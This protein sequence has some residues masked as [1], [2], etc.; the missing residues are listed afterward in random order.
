MKNVGRNDP[1]PCGSGKKYK[2]CHGASNVIEMNPTHYNV[3]LVRLHLELVEFAVSE[4]ENEMKNAMEKYVHP[5]LLDDIEYMEMFMD[6]LMAWVLLQEPIVGNQTLFELYYKS[7]QNKIKNSRVK[8]TFAEWVNAVPSI[9][10]VLSVTEECITVKDVR[11]KET[12]QISQP[13]ENENEEGNLLLGILIPYVQEYDFFCTALEFSHINQEVT[14]L[15]EQLSDE[16]MIR[17]YPDILSS[18]I[19]I[20]AEPFEPEWDNPLYEM[21]A[22]LF[23]KHVKEKGAEENIISLG[24]YI[25]VIFTVKE[26]PVFKKPEA[27]AAALDYVLQHEVLMDPFQSQKDL[28]EEYK[29]SATTISKHFRK[30]TE[31]IGQELEM[32]ISEAMTVFD[33][34]DEEFAQA[35]SE[36]D[37]L[38]DHLIELKG[39]R[40]FESE[41]EV[42]QF[43]EEVLQ[44]QGL[45]EGAPR[46]PRDIAQEKLYEAQQ[47]KGAKRRSLIKEALEI[48]PNSPDAYLLMGLDAKTDNEKYQ[49]LHQAV[50]AGEKDLGKAFFEENKGHFW[51]IPE[52]RAYMRA[53]A[54][55]ANF[56]YYFGNNTAAIKDFEELLELNPND[57]QGIRDLLLPIY[58]VEGKFDDAK[59][60]INRYEQDVTA[61]FMF[62]H[63]LLYFYSEGLTAKTKSLLKKADQQNPYVKDYLTG[64]KAMPR[65]EYQQFAIGDNREA[66]TYI[67]V[68]I[69]LWQ[70]ATELVKE[71]EKL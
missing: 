37:E 31:A 8:K 34:E 20:E 70:E 41:E 69:Q 43:L 32:A 55:F 57:N 59:A 47:A 27:Y 7:Q 61:A 58:I 28:A 11:T 14:N 5:D 38:M 29:V 10:E 17:N 23:T 33:D 52:T 60:L 21:V 22:D 2:K 67:Q 46:L 68:N 30:I 63:A 65:I 40:E 36:L 49:Y 56:Q 6:G 51:M 35:S 54:E 39:D 25:W 4:Y 50:I 26:T 18:T 44:N 48:Y 3:E 16:E 15:V 1:C 24:L 66:V 45:L 9:F 62:N 12:Y 64:K 42:K 13:M 53:K 19:I 71:F